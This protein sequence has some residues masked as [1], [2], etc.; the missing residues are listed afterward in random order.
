M[1]A[2]AVNM[3]RE[4]KKSVLESHYKVARPWREGEA[5]YEEPDVTNWVV[6]VTLP[7]VAGKFTPL[8]AVCTLCFE[9]ASVGIAASF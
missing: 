1:I 2:T 4:R 6:R 8:S 3:I 5:G 7:A 9:T